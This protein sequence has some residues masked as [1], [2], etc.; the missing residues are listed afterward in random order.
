MFEHL[1]DVDA[2]AS[3][4]ELRDLVTRCE[5]LKA[6]AAAAQARATALWAAQRRAAEDAAGVPARQRG[7][8]LASEIALARLDAPVCG[9]QHLGFANALV[10]EM[11]HTL[12]A[13][14]AGVLTEYRATLIVKA[15][16]CLTVEDRRV[17]DAELCADQQALAGLGNKRIEAASAAIAARLDAAAVVERKNRAAQSAGVWTRCAPN[18]MVYLTALM[19]LSQGIGVYAALKREADTTGGDGRSRGQVM[20]DT[21]YER[22]TARPADTPSPVALNL[23]LADTTLFGEDDSPGWVQGYGPVPA[24]VA[25]DL[26]S[27]AITDEAAK[28]TLRR[29]YRHP[30]SGQLVAMES[31]ARL[32]PKGLAAF[33]GL[34]DQT[35]RT[36]YCNAPIRHHDHATPHHKGG[37]TS[38]LNGAGSCETCNYAKEAPGW[39]VTT[40]DHD[41]RHTAEYRTPTGATYHST[42]PPLPG[43]TRRHST[44]EGRLGIDIVELKWTA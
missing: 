5:R 37:K 34:R 4:A 29:L 40:T 16:A 42:A 20:T 8:G 21:L 2:T 13:L 1:F 26:V 17:L 14:E 36:P 6:G 30:A 3:E 9:N 10:H 31:K 32:F 28:A 23:V 41:G 22:V 43:P 11:P 44:I 35:C 33:I 39:Q 12:A 7:R 38:A 19:P 25:R 15:S 24:A 18:G 27:D